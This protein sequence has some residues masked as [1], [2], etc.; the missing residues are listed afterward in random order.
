MEICRFKELNICE[1]ILKVVKEAG[2]EAPT[3]IQAKAIPR[4]YKGEDVIGQAQTGTGKTAAFAIPMIEKVN[5][6]DRNVQILILTPTRELAIQVTDE[7]KKFSRYTRGVK[8]LAIYGGQPIER[9]IKALKQGV[10]IVVGTPGRIL[11]HIRRKT[12]KLGG[13]TAVILDEA[14]QMLDMGFLEDIETILKEV[15]QDRQTLMFSATIPKEIEG[16]AKNYMKNPQKIKIVHKELTVPQ[17]AQYYFEV[18]SHEKLEAMCRILDMEKV[19][20]A[21]VFCNT[22][23]GVDELVEKL[24][25]RGYSVEGIH[26]DLKQSQRDKVMKKFR[27]GTTDLL[28]ATDVAARGIDV[29]DVALVINYDLPENFEYYVHRIGRTGRAGKV[30]LAYTFVTARQ[31]RTLK[32]LESY[33]KGKIKRKA[34]PTVS[35][36]VEKRKEEV[37]K[38]II[39]TIKEGKLSEYVHIIE[40]LAENY[41]SVDIGAALLKLLIDK[42]QIQLD[43]TN[44]DDLQQKNSKE[45]KM[46]RLFINV[47]R[48]HGVKPRNILGA[49]TAEAKINGDLVGD[50]SIYDKFSFVEIPEKYGKKVLKVMNNNQI[51]GRKVNIEFANSVNG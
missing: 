40:K 38:S 50:I 47:G 8:S 20:L 16:I 18:R 34:V 35:D 27:D 36:I 46:I 29:D 22:K 42:N 31:M 6:K 17:I 41:S 13:V 4:I 7:I 12:L 37:E 49:I 9:Q 23:K 14:D 45:S 3:P 39:S 48:K 33:I 51:K 28:V 2:Y 25:S 5:Y 26:G 11:D 44:E 30:G 32:A 19:D 43:E 10:Q 1:E 21:M 24:Q 15:P